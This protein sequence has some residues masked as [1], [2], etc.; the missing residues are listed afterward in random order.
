MVI[1][2]MDT[3]MELNIDTSGLAFDLPKNHSQ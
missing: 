1:G 3:E 2:P